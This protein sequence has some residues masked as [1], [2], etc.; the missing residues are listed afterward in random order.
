MS[1]SKPKSVFHL[2]VN[3]PEY[4]NVRL[5]AKAGFQGQKTLHHDTPAGKIYFGTVT[6]PR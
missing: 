2:G 6:K 1:L 4:Q 3:S 5:H